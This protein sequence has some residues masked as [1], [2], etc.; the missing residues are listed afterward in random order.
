MALKTYNWN[1]ALN[2]PNLYCYHNQYEFL[3]WSFNGWVLISKQEE[4]P[5]NVTRWT[6][7]SHHNLIINKYCT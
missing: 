1:L 7:S 6:E 4:S 2:Q 5:H 3:Q